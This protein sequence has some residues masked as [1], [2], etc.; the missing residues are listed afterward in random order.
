MKAREDEIDAHMEDLSDAL[1]EMR[2]RVGNPSITQMAASADVSLPFVYGLLSGDSVW[3]SSNLIKFVR[4]F[5]YEPHVVLVPI[6]R[7]EEPGF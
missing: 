2:A 4:A 3:K 6:R 1:L 5:G 7:E